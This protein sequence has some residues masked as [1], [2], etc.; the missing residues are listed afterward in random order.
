MV[1]VDLAIKA[2][3]PVQSSC[4]GVVRHHRQAGPGG[5]APLLRPS[6]NGDHD[7]ARQPLPPERWIG[8][9]GVHADE[10]VMNRPKSYSA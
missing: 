9:D 3:V 8:D 1:A 2:Q 6:Q 7:L 5:A 10:P 4:G